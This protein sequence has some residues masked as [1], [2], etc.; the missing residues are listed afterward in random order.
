MD[1]PSALPAPSLPPS[2]DLK[3][4]RTG[5]PATASSAP[6]PP[7]A[8]ISRA[9]ST[10]GSNNHLQINYLARQQPTDLSLIST[11]DTL[12]NV[13]KLVSEYAA[14]LDRHESLASNLGARPLGPNLLKRFERLFDG[15]PKILASHSHA[16]SPSAATASPQLTW[17][18]VIEFARTKPEQFQL[19]QMS[20]G[21][22]VCQFYWSKGQCRVQISEEDFLFVKSGRCEDLV[23]PLP[24]WEDEEKEVGTL[25]ILERALEGV[26]AVADQVAARVRQLN[27]RLKGRKTAILERRAA[28]PSI[29]ADFARFPSP[30]RT[31]SANGASPAVSPSQTANEA[32]AGLAN[33]HPSSGF[34]AVNSRPAS[35]AN[36]SRLHH[37]S[38]SNGNTVPSNSGTSPAVR[39]E[40][41]NTFRT[42]TERRRS[43]V[44]A[45]PHRP[46]AT[47]AASPAN[48]LSGPAPH[49]IASIGSFRPA[50]FSDTHDFDGPGS[51]LPTATTNTLTSPPPPTLRPSISRQLTATSTPSTPAA[52]TP[53]ANP[54]R[55]PLLTHQNSSATDAS[56]PDPPYRAL[57]LS[58]MEKLPRGARLIPPCDRCRRL[59]MDCLKNLTAC[60]GCT[61]KHARCA[62]RDVCDAE[63]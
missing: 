22:R 57:M 27:H 16:K 60:A 13:L 10:A 40:L 12:P 35:D 18:D 56:G 61:K 33:A 3:R 44:D 8:K 21:V 53:S 43:S 7:P 55:P 52:S 24:I 37:T 41:L 62:W 54:I 6:P 2:A 15:P 46:S 58:R 30:T 36:G 49:T 25:E 51:T 34:V 59:Q 17:L 39:N 50:S 29:R 28:N 38:V 14:V 31:T 26:R 11:D 32:L 45:R 48:G 9:N 47:P 19:G 63:V 23:P 4:K 42:N 5:S 1:F 20:E